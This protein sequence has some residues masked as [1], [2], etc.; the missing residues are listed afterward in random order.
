MKKQWTFGY[1]G[2]D[3][4]SANKKKLIKKMSVVFPGVE[5]LDRASCD[6]YYLDQK[7]I[8]THGNG[9]KSLRIVNK[10]GCRQGT[11]INRASAAQRRNQMEWNRVGR[12]A[13]RPT[14]WRGSRE[15]RTKLRAGK[16][17]NLLLLEVVAPR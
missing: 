16:A 8:I 15:E 2:V 1:K 6:D 4:N 12:E 9:T 10:G 17:T 3:L 7:V 5:E 14:C 13:R 11:S